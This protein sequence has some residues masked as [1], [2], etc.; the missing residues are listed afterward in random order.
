MLDKYGAG[1]DPYCYP[2]T[3][4]LR[5]LL[6]IEDAATLAQAERALSEAAA[7]TIEFL[8][9]PYDLS[10]LK[11]IHR[12]LFGDLYDWA[13]ELRTV[14]IS[15]DDTHFCVTGRI[16]PEAQKLFAS[17]AS[18][19]WFEGLDRA[20]LIEAVAELF[21]DLNVVHPFREG[22]GRAQ[23]ILF[24]HIIVNAGFSLSW[25]EVEMCEWTQANI[26]AV[27]CD[28]SGLQRIFAR[29]IGDRLT[30]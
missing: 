3:S 30:E 9:P 20:E 28:Y 14:D 18:A 23:R 8:P 19:S 29:C 16:E 1:Q 15:K 21:G 10:Y 26:D 6:G 11:H 27:V 17:L 22:N 5:N 4:Q 25:W 24:E 7:S 2:G 12:S 13:G